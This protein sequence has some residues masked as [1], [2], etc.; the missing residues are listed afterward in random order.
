MNFRKYCITS[1]VVG[2][3]WL[4]SGV[5]QAQVVP[6]CE[7]SGVTFSS[8][9][10]SADLLTRVQ[11][12]DWAVQDHIGDSRIVRS[13]VADMGRRINMLESMGPA[14]PACE[15]PA[16]QQA[17]HLVQQMEVAVSQPAEPGS[18]SAE[19]E[20]LDNLM[21][22][23]AHFARVVDRAAYLAPNVGMTELFR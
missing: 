13:R 11:R 20:S 18:L 8:L 6:S 1:A 10:R 7:T 12:D 17:A 2:A 23:D 19:A 16:V 3:A 5:L 22:T 21:R 4:S 14:V 15:Q 9:E